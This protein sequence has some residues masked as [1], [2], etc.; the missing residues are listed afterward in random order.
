[1]TVQELTKAFTERLAKLHVLADEV[2]ELADQFME[3]CSGLSLEEYANLTLLLR[4][5][6]EKTSTAKTRCTAVRDRVNVHFVIAITDLGYT[7][8]ATS[9][10]TFYAGA[11]GFFSPPSP[12]K[13]PEEFRALYEWLKNHSYDPNEVLF[14][15]KKL[16]VLCKD[17][18]KEGSPLPPNV[19]QFTH[20]SIMVRKK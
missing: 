17:L 6:R 4:A 5:A 15:K 2:T 3:V 16:S 13:S 20:A 14:S 19:K 10:H 11:D 18:M 9:N 7:Q 1:M 8:F 12:A